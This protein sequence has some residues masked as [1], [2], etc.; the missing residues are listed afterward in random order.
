MPTF[1]LRATLRSVPVLP[2]LVLHDPE[3][4]VGLARALVAGG[5]PVLEVTLRTPAALE[6]IRRMREVEGAIVGAGT[7]TRPEELEAA[8]DAGAAFGVSPGSTPALLAAARAVG[9]PF[10][11]GVATASEAMAA[12]DAGFSTLKFFPAVPAGGIPALKALA[13]PLPDLAFVPTG[14]IGA[15]DF[16]DFRALP[17]VLCVGGSWVAPQGAIE[18]GD[19][20]RIEALARATL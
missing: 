6:A 19:W 4:A 2:V 11:P 20:P 10:L 8:R 14:G 7:I 16:R 17:S 15:G 13:G 3:R 5:L 1:D 9:W 12:R 18:A